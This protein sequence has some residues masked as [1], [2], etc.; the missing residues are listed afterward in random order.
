LKQRSSGV[1]LIAIY[2]FF[3]G[4]LSLLGIC[5]VL[6]VPLIVG[7]STAASR[8]EGGPLAT[9]IV[10]TVMILIASVLFLVA[11]ANVVFGWGLWKQREW[12]RIGT[13][14]LAG[15]GLLKFPIGTVIGALIIW[16]LLREDVK[17][18]FQP[19]VQEPP[20]A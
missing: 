17:L 14:V 6:S 18:E 7:V 13:L 2:Q 9:A 16:Y 19:Q 5:G 10:S 1:T 12:A 20:Q 3:M 8:A 4:F 11:A 15:L